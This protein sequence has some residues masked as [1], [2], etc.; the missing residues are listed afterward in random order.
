MHFLSH[1]VPH[2]TWANNITEN[3]FRQYLALLHCWWLGSCLRRQCF[4]NYIYMD[5]LRGSPLHTQFPSQQSRLLIVPHGISTRAGCGTS[6]IRCVRG[7]STSVALWNRC[8]APV[9]P[10]TTPLYLPLVSVRL[11]CKILA[12]SSCC[13]KTALLAYDSLLTL[14]EEVPYIWKQKWK[15][16]TALYLLARYAN[17]LYILTERIVFFVNFTSLQVCFYDFHWCAWMTFN[18]CSKSTAFIVTR[19]YR[20][21]GRAMQWFTLPMFL[22]SHLSSAFKVRHILS[23]TMK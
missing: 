3:L 5:L 14:V 8:I 23:S 6:S 16:G 20:V 12:N 4:Q 1:L 10:W 18:K 15:L 9:W 21:L 19:I 2:D 22:A 11:V 13:L 17:I 7:R